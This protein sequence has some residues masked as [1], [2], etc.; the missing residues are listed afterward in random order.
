MQKQVDLLPKTKA[1]KVLWVSAGHW[2]AGTPV[3][4][5][6]SA[7]KASGSNRLISCILTFIVN[8]T[9]IFVSTHIY[10]HI[11]VNL[12]LWHEISTT[13]PVLYVLTPL[14]YAHFSSL[15]GFSIQT[16]FMCFIWYR[17]KTWLLFPAH[18]CC[19]RIQV[20]WH[21]V[22]LFTLKLVDNLVIS[23]FLTYSIPPVSE[24]EKKP[25]IW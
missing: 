12:H 13:P 24:T 22:T 4:P 10:R 20:L 7:L 2:E 1:E 8:C 6:H 14:L 25:T 15:S 21:L 3:N 19:W 16:K 5:Q 17:L 11:D 18:Y 23:I 9:L